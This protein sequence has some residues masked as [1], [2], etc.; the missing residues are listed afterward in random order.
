MARCPQADQHQLDPAFA[1]ASKL[2]ARYRA[3][4]GVRKIVPG[5]LEKLTPVSAAAD[6]KH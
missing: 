1:T 5:E 2:M 6:G 4:L 3:L